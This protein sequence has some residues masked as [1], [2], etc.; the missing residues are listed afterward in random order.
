MR[1][2]YLLV[3]KLTEILIE[4]NSLLANNNKK[5][6]RKKESE[7]SGEEE[8][9]EE[10]RRRGKANAPLQIYPDSEAKTCGHSGC[11]EKLVQEG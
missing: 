9:E 7:E 11:P 2:V 4:G 1:P 10:K 3:Q 8:E 6:K 5:E